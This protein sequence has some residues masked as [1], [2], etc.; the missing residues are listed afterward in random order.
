MS[1]LRRPPGSKISA[2]V[3]DVD[4]TLVTDEKRLTEASRNA[5]AALGAAGIAFAVVS[6]RPPRGLA[7]LIE[8]LAIKTPLAG[9]NG[10]MIA[11]PS[12]SVIEQHV[13]APEVA[14]R[15]VALIA[16]HGAEAWVFSGQDWLLRRLD[17]A[18]VELEKRT[19][20]FAP[21]LVTDF[22]EALGAANKIVGVSGDF[23]LLARCEAEAGATLGGQATVA[24]SQRYY[25]DITHPLANK[26]AALA[27][28]APRLAVPL[29]EIAVI[30]DGANDV[31]MFAQSGLSIAM[32][33]AAAE[34]Q[35]AADLVTDSNR[36]DGF[37]KAVE[38]FILGARASAR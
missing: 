17:G 10:G 19:V 15:A 36:E 6:S 20:R 21:T 34:V 30:G 16:A 13:L 5:V 4:G 33:N 25:L 7:M 9:F 12:L 24:R 8:A 28:L 14:R 26:G 27:A 32:G 22:G 2:L 18:Y 3:S 31:A 23:A 35:D 38:R 37:A 1:A 11:T 29:A